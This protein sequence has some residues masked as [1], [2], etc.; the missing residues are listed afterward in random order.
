MEKI[1]ITFHIYIF[2]I[3]REINLPDQDRKW[4]SWQP[5]IDFQGVHPQT[6][7]HARSIGQNTGQS[8]KGE[9]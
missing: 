4:N 2:I 6:F 9:K 7:V 8:C 3:L 5:P 1:I